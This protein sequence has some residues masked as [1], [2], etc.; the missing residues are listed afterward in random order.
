M[1]DKKEQETFYE[2]NDNFF[3]SLNVHGSHQ[4]MEPQLPIIETLLID[5][6]IF[7]FE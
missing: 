7:D 6:N 3:L 4:L 5:Q 1:A 2:A